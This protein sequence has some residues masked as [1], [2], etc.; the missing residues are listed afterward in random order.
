MAAAW[1]VTG[2]IAIVDAIWMAAGNWYFAPGEG[3]VRLGLA[4]LALL[5]PLL[6]V[7]YRQEPRI[8]GTVQAAALLLGFSAAGT[9]LSYLMV[10]TRAQL[11]DGPLADWDRSLGFDWV[12]LW[13]WMTGHP[14]IHTALRVA[15]HSGLAQIACVVLL[16][17]FGN[18]RA[19]LE[20]FVLA[21]VA[22]ALI[23]IGIS[24]P[25]PAAGP[26][27]HYSLASVVDVS[28]LS[29]FEPLRDGRLRSIDL[30]NMQ[31]LI[32]IPSMHAT[33][34]ILIVHALRGTR[35]FLPAVTLNAAMIAGTPIEGGHYVVDVIAGGL[36]AF[37]LITLRRPW[38]ALSRGMS[39]GTSQTD[40]LRSTSP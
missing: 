5:A 40:T 22:A 13:H 1:C 15:Y 29:H 4:M 18:R 17:G 35:W 8:S 11:I 21:Y 34:A 30:A 38:P 27:T 28:S 25:L 10:S 36:L 14:T 24:G 20:E 32:S 12:A 16:L 9:V 23:S 33:T 39:P 3:L 37:L 6:L 31:G 26:W 19:Q 7:R 2:L